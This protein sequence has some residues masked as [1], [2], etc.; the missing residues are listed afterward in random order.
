MNNSLNKQGNQVILR[1]DTID[2]KQRY[3]KMS[4]EQHLKMFPGAT[5]VVRVGTNRWN[6]QHDAVLESL[7]DELLKTL[8]GNQDSPFERLKQDLER[9]DPRHD[10]GDHWAYIM[11]GPDESVFLRDGRVQID[12]SGLVFKSKMR[13]NKTGNLAIEL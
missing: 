9:H 6:Q 10:L 12:I 5:D 8:Q 4:L 13:L 2:G 3:E 11:Y 7:V 1:G